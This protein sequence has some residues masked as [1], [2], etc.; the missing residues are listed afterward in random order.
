MIF[1]CEKYL[2]QS[3][4]AI[5]A[6]A[7]ASKSPIPA[8]E[9]LLITADEEITVTGFDLKEG[10]NSTLLAD[11]AERG[12]VVVNSHFFNEMIRRLPDGIV[13]VRVDEKLNVNVR[14]GDSDFNFIGIDPSDYPE[15]PE[16]DTM[17]TLSLPQKILR[18]MISQTIFSVADK[19]IRPVYTGILFE[20]E[21]KVLTLVAV[22]GYRLAKRK[23]VI[24]DSRLENCSFIVPGTALSDVERICS[25]EDGDVSVS[26]GRKHISFTIGTTTV[27]TRRLEGEFLNYRRSIPTSFKY[28]IK[29]NRSEFMQ[30]IDR[31]ALIVSD[32]N[33]SP[34]RMSFQ[35][36]KL[37]CLCTT[38]L[39]KAEDFCLCDGDASGLEIGFN[40]RYMSDAL[41]AATG[42]D[43]LLLCFNSSTTPCV[44]TAADG[45]DKFTYMILPVR[46][47]AGE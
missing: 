22:D 19:D 6:R 27:I 44:I 41:K 47:R 26:V 37:R 7:A 20:L 35:N 43:E 4:C 11:I 16:V 28:L 25:D 14:C 24:E 15:M 1:T 3:A 21:E 2:L 30:T 10:I 8:L 36:G 42:E 39:G 5:C 45:G 12:S 18:S 32:K 31:V 13:T 46:L 29:V 17:H 23:E 33:T 40:D 34:V 9:G 38:P